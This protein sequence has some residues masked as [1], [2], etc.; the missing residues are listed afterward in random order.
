MGLVL[1]GYWGKVSS[2]S[3]DMGLVLLGYWR[4]VSSMS[5]DISLVLEKSVVHPG[6]GAPIVPGPCP[7][8]WMTPFPSTPTVPGPC[9][10]TTLFSSTPT[11]PGQCHR[12]WMTQGHGQHFSLGPRQYHLHASKSLLPLPL[13]SF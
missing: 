3:W 6:H 10:R 13:H 5:W 8:T 4:K 7:R 9:P 12:T 2:M 1:L 11:V